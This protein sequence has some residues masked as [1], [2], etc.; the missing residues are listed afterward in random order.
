MNSKDYEAIRHIFLPLLP[1]DILDVGEYKSGK[2]VGAGTFPKPMVY[3]EFDK[4]GSKSIY[5]ARDAEDKLIV[6]KDE[7]EQIKIIKFEKE[8]AYPVVFKRDL[9]GGTAPQY[10]FEALRLM[11]KFDTIIQGLGEGKGI[12]ND[13]VQYRTVVIDSMTTM[14]R[15]WKESILCNQKQSILQIPDYGTLEA[16]LFALF[17]PSIKALPMDFK[18]FIAHIE[19]EKNEVDGRTIEYPKGPSRNQGKCL[20]MEFSEVWRQEELMGRYVWRTKK[21]VDI[22]PVGS[23]LHLPDMTESNFNALAEVVKKREISR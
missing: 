20:G 13:G 15:L 5:N 7:W 11:N 17:I 10:T 3:F 8:R 2:S 19:L 1:M 12:D 9:K 14:Y 23:R 22:M 21:G 4:D 6:P 18:I 16:M